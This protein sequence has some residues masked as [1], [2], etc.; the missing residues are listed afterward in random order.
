MSKEELIF[1]TTKDLKKLR[2]KQLQEQNYE[3]PILGIE[4]KA[5]DSVLDHRHKLKNEKV[6]GEEGLGCLRGVIH[7]NVNTFE[8]KV[9]R[10][11]KRYGLEKMISLPDLL[12]KVA[13]Y[14]ENPPMKKIY[15]HPNER[16]KNE[17]LSKKEY[18]RVKKYYFCAYPNK[19]KLPLYPKNRIK[20]EKWIEFIN[21]TNK[22]YEKEKAKK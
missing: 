22:I 18:N 9:W 2:R 6:G 8:G 4:L 14:I 11:W 10:I 17:K 12:R 5:K 13:D 1:L 16:S 15:V 19:R 20:T 3:C 7:R 21:E